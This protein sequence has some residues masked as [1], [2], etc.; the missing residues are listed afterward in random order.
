M[1]EMSKSKQRAEGIAGWLVAH[2][3]H[4]DFSNERHGNTMCA[5]LRLNIIVSAK[6]WLKSFRSVLLQASKLIKQNM[7]NFN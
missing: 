3:T 5:L 1:L 2:A 6:F 7:K 4:M